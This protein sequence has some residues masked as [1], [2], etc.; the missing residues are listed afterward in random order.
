MVQNFTLFADISAATNIRTTK[1][2]LHVLA[3][4]KS[5]AGA[6]FRTTKISAEGQDDKSK[7]CTSKG[8]PLYGVCVLDFVY[9]FACNA[10]TST[11]NQTE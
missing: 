3:R 2:S 4:T 9:T 6:K 11:Y 5:S 7:I 10:E 8:F 1:M